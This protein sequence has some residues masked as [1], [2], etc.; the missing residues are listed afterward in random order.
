[1]KNII[2]LEEEVIHE[3]PGTIVEEEPVVEDPAKQVVIAHP[4]VVAPEATQA[5]NASSGVAQYKKKRVG[6]SMLRY[7]KY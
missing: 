7:R 5:V 1:V 3:F 2:D 4:L 6:E